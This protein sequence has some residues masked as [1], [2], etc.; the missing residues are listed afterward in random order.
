MNACDPLLALARE[1]VRHYQAYRRLL[2]RPGESVSDQLTMEG[3]LALGTITAILIDQ[4]DMAWRS[5]VEEGLLP[6]D[7]RT[8]R[9]VQRLYETWLNPNPVE[10]RSFRFWACR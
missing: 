9:A 10:T 8:E 5:K 3:V 7:P 2:R 1:Q 6:S 4:A